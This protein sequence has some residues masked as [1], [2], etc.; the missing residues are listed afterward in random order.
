MGAIVRNCRLCE[1][2]MELNPLSFC[3]ACLEDRE[4]I[5]HYI[6]EHPQPSIKQI[7]KST[8]ISLDKIYKLT[9]LKLPHN[10]N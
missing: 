3:P 7:A 1:V 4:K 10:K 6:M 2:P 8:Q 5:I 9:S